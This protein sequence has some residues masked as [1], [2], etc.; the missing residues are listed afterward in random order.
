MPILQDSNQ[1]RAES[2]PGFLKDIEALPI[3]AKVGHYN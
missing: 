3:R 2:V 1:S